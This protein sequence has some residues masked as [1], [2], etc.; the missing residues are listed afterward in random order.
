MKKLRHLRAIRASFGKLV[1]LPVRTSMVIFL[2]TA[3]G[4]V[5]NACTGAAVSNESERVVPKPTVSVESIPVADTTTTMV[6]SEP[7]D[8]SVDALTL[9]AHSIVA[10]QEEVIGDIYDRLVPSVVRI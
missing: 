9:D 1:T 4:I 8:S 5:S 6:V 3:M 7:S 2:A 10:A